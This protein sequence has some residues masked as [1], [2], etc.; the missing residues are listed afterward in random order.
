MINTFGERDH[1]VSFVPCKDYT[2]GVVKAA[3]TAAFAAL[4]GLRKHL[5]GAKTVAVKLNLVGAHEP[6]DA[7]TTHPALV[8]ELCRELLDFGVTKVILGDSPGGAYTAVHLKEIYEKTGFAAMVSE[9]GGRVV[10]NDNLTVREVS[11][12]EGKVLKSFQYAAWTDEADVL[13]NFCKLKTHGMMN[14]TCAVKNMFGMIPGMTKP[15]YHARFPEVERFSDMLIDL[16]EY[17]RPVL[18]LCDAVECMEGNGPTKGTPRHMGCLMVSEDPYALDVLAGYLIGFDLTSLPVQRQAHVRGL[19]PKSVDDVVIV[20]DRKAA[21]SFRIEDFETNTGSK[22]VLFGKGPFAGV[23]EFFMNHAFETHPGV[24]PESCIGC[25]RCASM[26]PQKAITMD[27]DRK[28]VI[29]RKKCIR[30]FC[31]QEFCPVGAMKVKRTAIAHLLDAF[32][33]KK[34]K[35]NG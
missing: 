35:N 7:A 14:L 21:L 26:C 13:V 18:N 31:C 28:P 25:G 11:N 8:R 3:M 29:D 10:L 4:G 19:G 20:P 17:F 9:F 2:E 1:S 5:H 15:Q 30:C 32:S 16:G 23:T 33:G 22:S 12:P 6:Q 34:T 24:N 27:K